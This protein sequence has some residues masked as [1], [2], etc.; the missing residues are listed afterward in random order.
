MNN[1]KPQLIKGILKS[2]IEQLKKK[3]AFEDNEIIEAWNKAVGKKIKLHTKLISFKK[4]DLIVNTESSSWLFELQTNHKG[5]ILKSLKKT[6]GE[7]K[8]KDI[9]FKVGEIKNTI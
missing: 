3:T 1:F 9:R 4:H 6:L 7:D 5:K 8:I 2:I